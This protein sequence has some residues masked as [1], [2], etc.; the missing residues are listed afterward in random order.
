MVPRTPWFH[1][2][3]IFGKVLSYVD[4]EAFNVLTSSNRRARYL[5]CMTPELMLRLPPIRSFTDLT[6]SIYRFFATPRMSAYGQVRHSGLTPEQRAAIETIKPL[7]K[8]LVKRHTP[9]VALEEAE[10]TLFEYLG[11]INIEAIPH[12]VQHLIEKE[13]QEA[14]SLRMVEHFPSSATTPALY[15]KTRKGLTDFFDLLGRITFSE[16]HPRSHIS[17]DLA[18]RAA[19]L[20]FF[21][22]ARRF[23]TGIIGIQWLQDQAMT[24]IAERE[25]PYNREVQ[26][27]M[28]LPTAEDGI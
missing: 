26:V 1:N 18:F 11:Q 14:F 2:N 12:I 15:L 10:R 16:H 24:I 19:D 8:Q 4:P 5:A 28:D 21:T 20:E 3:D 9:R 6:S 7:I 23:S 13:Q 17:G 27:L 22:E 25:A